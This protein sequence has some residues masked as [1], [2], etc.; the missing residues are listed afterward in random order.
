MFHVWKEVLCLGSGVD[1]WGRSFKITSQH[2]KQGHKNARLM[3]SR[4]V[5]CPLVWE[6]QQDIESNRIPKDVKALAEWKRRYAKFTFGHVG[7]A[8]INGRGNL[9]LR[10]DVPD[11]ND[12]KQLPK[13]RFVSPKLYPSYSD[14]RGG[15]YEGTT[16][17]H[18]A[19]TPTPVQFWQKPFELSRDD[20]IYFSYTPPDAEG[21]TVADDDKGDKGD[22]D[23]K[24][25]DGKGGAGSGGDLTALI[26]AL[27]EVN[28]TIPEEVTDI[29][30][31]IIAVKA[32]GKAGGGDDDLNL[33]DDDA[34]SGADAGAG[35]GTGDTTAAGA[36]APM[37]MSDERAEP[38][39]KMTRRDLG[40]RINKLMKSGRIDRPTAQKLINQAKSIEL[41][42]TQDAVL[43]P[44]ALLTK[45][46]AFESLPKG[47]AWTGKGGKQASEELELSTTRVDTPKNLT[48][49]GKESQKATTDWLCEKLP[50]PAAK[51]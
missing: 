5:P 15:R 34:A 51:K 49:G 23:K 18:V 41:S 33:D 25:K 50:A 12:A 1:R 26:E 22:K 43:Q 11:A 32:G 8:R 7:G 42:F 36:S 6:H 4:G 2:I 44:N 19:A 29:P 10:H 48:A 40:G 13:V 17:A 30:G 27:R 37:L 24:G 28:L 14:S 39:R 35:G 47:L 3:L 46:E 31:L 21:S 20:A 16:I 9:E 38:F 45:I